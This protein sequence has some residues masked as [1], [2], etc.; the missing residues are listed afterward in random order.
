MTFLDL[1]YDLN[2][3]KRLF[4]AG[5]E[6]SASCCL[7][8]S[9]LIT[10]I[11]YKGKSYSFSDEIEAEGEIEFKRLCRRAAKKRLYGV[12]KENTGI[13]LPWGSLTGI[14]PV[15]LFSQTVKEMGYEEAQRY[16]LEF[17]DVSPSK[18][19]LLKRIEKVQRKYLADDPKI[20]DLYAGIPF[21][22]GRCSYCSFISAEIEKSA[23]L[24]DSYAFCLIKEIEFVK[25]IIAKNGLK[26]NSVYVGGGTP[27]SLPLEKLEEILAALKD[28]EA[29]EFTFEAGRPDSFSEELMELLKRAGVNRISVNPQSSS[30]ETLKRIGRRHT[31]SDCVRAFGLSEKYGFIVNM[32]IIAGLPGESLEDFK[33]TADAVIALRPHNITVHTLCVKNGAL[34]A[35]TGYSHTEC[36]SQMLDYAQNALH[37]SG[38]NAYYMYR[39]K[40]AAGNLENV[41][42][43]LPGFECLYNIDNMEDSVT[44]AACGANAISKRVFSGGRIERLANPKDIKTYCSKI[45][46]LL[47]KKELFF[48]G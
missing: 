42:Y 43:S 40:N 36:A 18:L 44:V 21:C 9:R 48:S 25:N 32:D 39:Q 27:S 38:Y 26:V 11:E 33:R 23:G 2:D 13:S 47:E 28:I 37:N 45:D 22:R 41:G 1:S 5:E 31:F 34:L 4:G 6:V 12:L 30:D 14:R 16:F 8:G 29:G 20:C 7:D 19:E 10:E 46:A 17:F 24:I 15:R 3:I 35:R